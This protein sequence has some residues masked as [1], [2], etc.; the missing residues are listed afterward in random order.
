VNEESCEVLWSTAVERNEFDGDV[1]WGCSASW[2]YMV[3]W[4]TTVL[5]K[6]DIAGHLKTAD[7]ILEVLVE[8]HLYE[9]RTCGS[10]VLYPT[11]QPSER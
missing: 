8:M 3:C 5:W 1:Y 10:R 4:P 6:L 9:L 7:A 2:D 11:S